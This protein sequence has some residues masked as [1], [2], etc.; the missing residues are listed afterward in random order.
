MF[1]FHLPSEAARLS[2]LQFLAT[3]WLIMHYFLTSL[4]NGRYSEEGGK[5]SGEQLMYSYVSS[6]FETP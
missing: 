5:S 4:C 3:G 6:L 1:G 2:A